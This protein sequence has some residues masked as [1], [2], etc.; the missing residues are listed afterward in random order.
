MEILLTPKQSEKLEFYKKTFPFKILSNNIQLLIDNEKR[1][2]EKIEAEQN[3][4]MKSLNSSSEIQNFIYSEEYYKNYHKYE[5]IIKY[6]DGLAE[7]YSSIMKKIKIGETVENRPIFVYQIQVPSG[8]KKQQMWINSLQHAREW[9]SAPTTQ[10]I[11]WKL[12]EGYKKDPRITKFL[13]GIDIHYV[14]VLNPD[15]FIHTHT[16]SRLWRKNRRGGYGVDLNRNWKAG[17][18][19]GSSSDRN[20]Q[21]YR[22]T[23]P[24]SEP[25]TQAVDQYIKKFQIKYGIDFHCYSE[26]LLRPWGKS[27]SPSDDEEKFVRIGKIIID[28]IRQ[29]NGRA[30]RNWR[31]SQLGLGNGLDDEF[32]E[33]HKFDAGFTQELRPS[34]AMGGGFHLPP[35]QILDTAKENFNGVL[36]FFDHILKSNQ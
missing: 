21:V 9:I 14:P 7:K 30:Y 25:E 8:T 5:D 6:V 17:W 36:E 27:R 2:M 35:A 12:L 1:E 18:G 10:F 28:G 13:E 31:A 22:G 4:I 20:S 3:K 19:I 16:S 32:Y 11:I 29:V 26:V 15:G 33:T 23:A 34:G 24:L